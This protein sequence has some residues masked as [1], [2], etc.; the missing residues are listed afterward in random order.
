VGDVTCKKEDVFE[1][2]LIGPWHCTRQ[3]KLRKETPEEKKDTFSSINPFMVLMALRDACLTYALL[4][5]QGGL[6]VCFLFLAKNKNLRVV[7]LLAQSPGP[8]LQCRCVESGPR[9]RSSAWSWL[10]LPCPIRLV[11]KFALGW[12]NPAEPVSCFPYQ[13]L[14]L[15]TIKIKAVGC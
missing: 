15:L 4:L 1:H 8:R 12:G 9:F 13:K 6:F 10:L 11:S 2:L 5:S 3:G 14:H 7:K